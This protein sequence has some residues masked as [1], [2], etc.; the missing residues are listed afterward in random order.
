VQDGATLNGSIS[1]SGGKDI[2][3]DTSPAEFTAET[4]ASNGEMVAV[5]EQE[6]SG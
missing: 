6:H 1:M 5:G 4:E 2:G 3:D